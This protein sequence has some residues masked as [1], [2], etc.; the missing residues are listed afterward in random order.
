MRQPRAIT[1]MYK[2]KILLNYTSK[3]FFK[4][5]S[6][7]RNELHSSRLEV[8]GLKSNKCSS[9]PLIYDPDQQNGSRL[10]SLPFRPKI[11]LHRL[12]YMHPNLPFCYTSSP[13]FL[14]GLY[15]KSQRKPTNL[16]VKFSLAVA[17]VW[18]HLL[19][20][21]APLSVNA[22]LAMQMAFRFPYCEDCGDFFSFF[23]ERFCLFLG[24]WRKNG[25][26]DLKV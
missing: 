11:P 20:E 7:D 9:Y 13:T 10:P 5:N 21:T 23:L 12:L 16:L 6:L 17:D 8:L 26:K 14:S 24:R 15:K 18:L 25:V 19:R 4:L 1:C 2:F 3:A 22:R